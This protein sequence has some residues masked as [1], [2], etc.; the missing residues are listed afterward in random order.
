MIWYLESEALFDLLFFGAF[1]NINI[2]SL[3]VRGSLEIKLAAACIFFL[4]CHP[5]VLALPWNLL[6]WSNM[7]LDSRIKAEKKMISCYFF[8]RQKIFNST[9]VL[10]FIFLNKIPSTYMKIIFVRY[11]KTLSE[12]TCLGYHAMGFLHSTPVNN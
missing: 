4:F 6:T 2:S 7:A 3:G 11:S 10:Y 8:I 5:P 9:I 1:C 12:A